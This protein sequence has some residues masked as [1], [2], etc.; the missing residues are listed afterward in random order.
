MFWLIIG[1]LLALGSIPCFIHHKKDQYSD[2]YI[3]G[4]AL[5]VIG[6]IWLSITLGVII[7]YASP[8][9]PS[10]CKE[11]QQIQNY[12][13]RINDIRNSYYKYNNKNVIIAGS[14]ENAYQST[15]LSEYI[16]LVAS[17]ESQYF[18]D[19]A[20]AKAT[21]EN[22]ISYFFE[23]GFMISNKIYELPIK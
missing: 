12:K 19:L 13:I 2:S 3:G 7:S 14:I 8:I 4:I 21:K 17:L 1:F 11:Y 23:Y 9:Y 22:F 6:F 15:N 5:I 20:E 18:S 10:L 16:K